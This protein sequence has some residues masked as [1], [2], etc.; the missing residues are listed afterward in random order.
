MSYARAGIESIWLMPKGTAGSFISGSTVANAISIGFKKPATL[1]IKDAETVKDYLDREFKNKLSY[2]LSVE[3]LQSSIDNLWYLQGFAINNG[4]DVV[5]FSTGTTRPAGTFYSNTDSGIFIFSKVAGGE[6][7]S[8]GIDYEV[9]IGQKERTIKL[10]L[11]ATFDYNTGLSIQQEAQ[12]NKVILP[13]GLSLRNERFDR[14]VLPRFKNLYI[15]SDGNGSYDLEPF[16]D[17]SEMSDFKITLKTKGDKD[18]FGRSRLN[19]ITGNLEVTT[20]E[21]KVNDFIKYLSTPI[22]AG[23]KILLGGNSTAKDEAFIINNYC[24]MSSSELTIGDAK[25]E[26]KIMLK[27]D[28]PISN[29]LVATSASLDTITLN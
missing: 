8:L 23:Y 4:C 14:L 26:S 28:V 19:Y 16:L 22:N 20:N 2:S 13:A 29:V 18:I 11:E 12:T 9:S 17:K 24:L 3:T 10:T 1:V 6:D 15:D 25:R 21:A 7:K 27:G 5:M